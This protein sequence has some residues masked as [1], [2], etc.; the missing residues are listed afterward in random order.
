MKTRD[1]PP[2]E[3]LK[4]KYLTASWCSR[5]PD[6]REQKEPPLLDTLAII[7]AGNGG[8]AVAA[9]M[10][11]QGRSVR[12]FEF[13][14]YGHNTTA[15]V[16]SPRLA[17][18]GALEGQ[19]TLEAV[20]HELEEA[21]GGADAVIVCTQGLT[22]Q[23]LARELAHTIQPDQL[24][25]LCPGSTGGSLRMAH[26]LRQAGA[27]ALPPVVEFS[28]LPYGCRADGNS[29]HIAVRAARVVY[30]VFPAGA[31]STP[32]RELEA[33][34]PGLVRGATALE[35]ALNNGNPIIHPAIALLNAARIENDGPTMLFYR[36]GVSPATARLIQRLD[37]E[38]MA[39]LQALGHAAQPEPVTSVAQGYAQDTDYYTCYR[40]G[41]GFVGFHSP[42]TLDHRYMHE[43]V[44]IGLATYVGLGR[45][46]GVS[47]PASEAVVAF[48]SLVTG[49]DFRSG[50]SRALT[51][52]GIEGMRPHQVKRYMVTGEI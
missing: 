24:L 38:R 25:V 11:S 5:A 4:N 37:D 1:R 7:G 15:L 16:P 17:V 41:T 30:G 39:L 45:F 14:E 22:H 43:D 6:S 47:T 9:D 8:K 50:V 40:R 34:F 12:L 31:A 20:T 27:E 33:A 28:T 26:G 3:S 23:R 48:A 36:D 49:T 13:P 29:V 46:L 18:T 32:V 44:G 19:V 51:D 21:V 2:D 10:A 35:A 42:H 52:M